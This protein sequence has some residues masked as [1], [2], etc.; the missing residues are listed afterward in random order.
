MVMSSM[1]K[2]QEVGKQRVSGAEQVDILLGQSTKV[3]LEKVSFEQRPCRR[4]GSWE[5]NYEIHR[6]WSQI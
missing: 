1:K 2:K 6:E 4:L 5:A 3:L